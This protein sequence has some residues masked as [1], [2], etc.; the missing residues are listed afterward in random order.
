M[1]EHHL[2]EQARPADPCVMVIFGASGD[3]TKRKLVPSLLNLAAYRLLSRDF[4]VVGFAVDELDDDSFRERMTAAVTEFATAPDAAAEWEA[5]RPHF[6]YVRGE[7]GDPAAFQRLKEKLA[8]VDADAGT[9]GNRIYYL[10]TPPA[11]FCEV[12]KQLKAAG[13]V[14]AVDAHTGWTRM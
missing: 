14:N 11:F 10:A 1:E 9:Q 3:L 5:L 12:A 4:A 6:H 7:F 2:S 13:L 8:E